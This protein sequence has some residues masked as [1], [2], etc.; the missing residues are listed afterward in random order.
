MFGLWEFGLLL[1]IMVIVFGARRL[2]ALGETIGRAVAKYRS[3][4]SSRDAIDVER[5]DASPP[6]GD[7]AG[8]EGGGP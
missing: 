2:P 4:A 3:A 7:G 6:S 1:I 8:D 5:V